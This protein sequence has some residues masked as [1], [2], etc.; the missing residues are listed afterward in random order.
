MVLM[1][2]FHYCQPDL[3]RLKRRA[4]SIP[5]LPSVAWVRRVVAGGGCLIMAAN[6]MGGISPCTQTRH[7]GRVTAQH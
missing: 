2:H 1:L 6:I 5:A 7:R 3:A 4:V